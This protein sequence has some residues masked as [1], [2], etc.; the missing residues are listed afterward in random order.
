MDVESAILAYPQLPAELLRAF[1]ISAERDADELA[2]FVRSCEESAG[3]TLTGFTSPMLLGLGLF[4]RFRRWESHGIRGHI[5][6]GLPTAEQMLQS[7]V[8]FQEVPDFEAVVAATCQQ[9]SSLY[10]TN[11]VWMAASDGNVELALSAAVDEDRLLD[12]VADFLIDT[13]R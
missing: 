5:E 8:D 12:A 6:A 3:K 2:A 9:A 10:Y 4:V 13:D 1:V 11:F 7:V